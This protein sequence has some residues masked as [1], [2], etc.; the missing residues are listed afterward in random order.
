M[1]QALGDE[2]VDVFAFNPEPSRQSITV[3]EV[4]YLGLVIFENG[5]SKCSQKP[6]WLGLNEAS[7]SSKRALMAFKGKKSLFLEL[8]DQLDASD[9]FL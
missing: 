4:L 7:C 2:F 8:S 1:N 9:V 3:F 5:R 6:R